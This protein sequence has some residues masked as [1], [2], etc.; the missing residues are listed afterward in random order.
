[1]EELGCVV[2]E[3]RPGLVA[4][5]D[6]VAEYPEEE[7]NVG[8]YTSD[9][10]LDQRSEHLSS[11]HLERGTFHRDLDQQRVV[12]RGDLCT[13]ETGRGIQSDSVTTCGTVDFDLAGVG[14]E[15][16]LRIL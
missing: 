14:L 7:G 9:S 2:D 5:E 1:M 12:V 13:S 8:L 16:G 10:E 3:G 4:A 6:L 11:G 15:V